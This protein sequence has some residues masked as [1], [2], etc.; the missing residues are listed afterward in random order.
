MRD[1]LREN[2][3]KMASAMRKHGGN[4]EGKVRFVGFHEKYVWKT[5]C[6]DNVR[7]S[8][9]ALELDGQIRSWYDSSRPGEEYGCRCRA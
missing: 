9:K 3:Y 2:L 1:L 6:D 4:Q 5:V 7:K 8:H